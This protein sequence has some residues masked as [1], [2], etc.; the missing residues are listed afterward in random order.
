MISLLLV[1]VK[2]IPPLLVAALYPNFLQ[3]RIMEKVVSALYVVIYPASFKKDK[4]LD[5]Y[6]YDEVRQYHIPVSHI[7]GT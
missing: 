6:Y 3:H 5:C 7:T 1:V 2:R 4:G